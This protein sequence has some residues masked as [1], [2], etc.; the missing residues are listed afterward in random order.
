M[1][2]GSEIQAANSITGRDLTYREICVKAVNDPAYF[3]NFRSLPNYAPILELENG[4]PFLEYLIRHPSS[5]IIGKMDAFGKLD[6]IGKPHTCAFMGNQNFSGTTLRYIVIAQNIQDF[7][8]LPENAKIAEIGAGFGGQCYILSQIQPFSQYYI[9]DLPEV[10]SLIKKVLGVLSVPH[11]SCMPLEAS[12]PEEKI[13]LLISNYA[14]SEC[15]RT[16]QLSYFERV[17][18]KSDRGYMMYN[19]I[20]RRF[21]QLDSLTPNEFMKLLEENDMNPKME[22]EPIST[23]SDNVLITWDRTKN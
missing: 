6:Q 22:N 7:F 4:R 20:A 23:Y 12:I 10:E 1:I 8:Q 21:F 2:L 5:I 13:D 14:Y 19:Q 17:V 15:D 11:V 9:Y 3:K 16:T 18:K